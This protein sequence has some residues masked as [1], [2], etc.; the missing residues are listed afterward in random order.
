MSDFILKNNKGIF[1]KTEAIR[2]YMD[3]HHRE[4]YQSCQVHDMRHEA[5]RGGHHFL[6]TNTVCKSSGALIRPSILL[7]VIIINRG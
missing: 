2:V 5:G 4:Q 3:D 1:T 7:L 6:R